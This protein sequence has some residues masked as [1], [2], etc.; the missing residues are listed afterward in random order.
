MIRNTHNRSYAPLVLISLFCAAVMVST[1]SVAADKKKP[2]WLPPSFAEYHDFTTGESYKLTPDELAEITKEKS[3]IEKRRGQFRD[4]QRKAKRGIVEKIEE[5]DIENKIYSV[6]FLPISSEPNYGSRV[7]I[8]VDL[9]YNG[10]RG[11]ASFSYE[12]EFY[13]DSGN[14]PSMF[15]DVAI[16]PGRQKLTAFIKIYRSLQR[17]SALTNIKLQLKDAND[18][19]IIETKLDEV[20]DWQLGK[21]VLV[22]TDDKYGLHTAVARAATLLD[23]ARSVHELKQA[24]AILDKVIYDDPD[25]REAYIELARYHMKQR[26][27]RKVKFKSAEQILQEG[28]SVDPNYANTHVLLGYVYTHQQRYEQA[29]QEFELAEKLGTDNLWLYT[30]WGELYIKTDQKDKA[31]RYFD[32]VIK[33]G[34][35]GT[36]NDR[37]LIGAYRL[38][39]NYLKQKYDV[40]KMGEV[41]AV[42]VKDF[43]DEGCYLSEYAAHLVTYERELEKSKTLAKSAASSSCGRKDFV[44]KV[45]SKVLLVRSLYFNYGEGDSADKDYRRSRALY[46]DQARIIA[47]LS[48][49]SDMGD[50]YQRLKQRR[51]ISVDTK[52]ANG[53]TALAYCVSEIRYTCVE[54]LLSNGASPNAAANEEGWSLLMVAVLSNDKP[55]IKRLLIAGAD[56]NYATKEGITAHTLAGYRADKDVAA[57]LKDASR[58]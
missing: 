40:K 9:Q 26:K 18:A 32:K 6:K 30:N 33:T 53:L 57:M 55:M 47:D 10:K 4:A 41:H 13:S 28:V 36:R 51:G 21:P 5:Q 11:L 8:E 16:K 25:N 19:V 27:N 56:P 14:K 15:S 22:R 54:N 24:K 23:S 20:I 42:R 52:G 1:G 48:E 46:N 37:A 38:Y 3:A 45:L 35:T 43:N 17:K 2:S 49:K 50:L 31:Y 58:I 12:S 34:R 29:E 7:N 39:L 44:N